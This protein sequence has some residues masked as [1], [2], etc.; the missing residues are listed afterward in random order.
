MLLSA[1]PLLR[2]RGAGVGVFC[3]C[4]C[5]LCGSPVW[6]SPPVVGPLRGP[7]LCVGP[8]YAVW[9]E[10]SPVVFPFSV[11]SVPRLASRL[12]SRSLCSICCRVLSI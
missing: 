11:V 5:V 10:S 1:S 7:A 4:V 3:L 9:V 12:R 6:P 8:V 2:V